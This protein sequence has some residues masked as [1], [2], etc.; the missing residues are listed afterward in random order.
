LEELQFAVTYALGD[1][2]HHGGIIRHDQT[3]EFAWTL[4]S[5]FYVAKATPDRAPAW[6]LPKSYWTEK[7]ARNLR[8]VTANYVNNPAEKTATFSSGVDAGR[9]PFWQED[10][11]AAVLGV[12]VWMGYADWTPV[13]RWK[14]KSNIARANGTSGWPRSH[15]TLYYAEM[16]P[17][18]GG[19]PAKNWRELALANKLDPTTN[20]TLDPKV[21]RNYAAFARAALALAVRDGVGDAAKPYQWLD[22]E[23]RG[24]YIPWR[25]AFD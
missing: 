17:A 22:A 24:K 7:L 13:L 5:L 19:A 3:R 16:Q 18:G 12:G 21:D 10:Y 8:W 4:R 11:L 14:I 15:P 2:P 1:Y 20:E 6:L 9:L 25:W 23:I